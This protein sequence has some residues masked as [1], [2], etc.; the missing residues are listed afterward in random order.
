M[1]ELCLLAAS[2]ETFSYLKLMEALEDTDNYTTDKLNERFRRRSVVAHAA[3]S[4]CFD[5]FLYLI[6]NF[7]ID[8]STRD[9]EFSLLFWAAKNTSLDTL[10]YIINPQNGLL[11]KLDDK[12][13]PLHVAAFKGDLDEVKRL[14]ALDP[15][16]IHQLD[17]NH[18][19]ALFY[20]A[21]R[22]DT[23]LV[24][25]LTQTI[26][27]SDVPQDLDRHYDSLNRGYGHALWRS[28][29]NLDNTVLSFHQ[30]FDLYQQ[31]FAYF[32]K[33]KHVCESDYEDLVKSCERIAVSYTHLTLPTI[34]SV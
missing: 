13:T 7:T 8:L 1:K 11:D 21:L 19:S 31:S 10:S 34:Y 23:Q 24:T 25:Y 16:C 28:A 22:Q 4:G 26:E 33:I 29:R 2:N 6:N 5:T 32:K 30:E 15:A 14:I 27:T 18:H 9:T 17:K 20:A 3:E 12:T